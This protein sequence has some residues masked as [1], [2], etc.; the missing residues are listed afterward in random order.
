MRPFVKP[1]TTRDCADYLGFSTQWIRRAIAEGVTLRD[2][3]IV[4]LEAEALTLPGR[5]TYRIDS[6]QF[7]AFLVA[8]GRKH[9]PALVHVHD[10]DAPASD[11]VS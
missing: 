11:R 4:K 9:V 1:L 7:A 5:T 3:Q 8:I 2:G 10:H 6:D